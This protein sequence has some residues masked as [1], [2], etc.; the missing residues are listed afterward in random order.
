MLHAE[1]PA[2]DPMDGLESQRHRAVWVSDDAASLVFDP[3]HGTC[4]RITLDERSRV[5]V[6]RSPPGGS[7]A[8]RSRG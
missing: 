4:I 2:F 3:N 5:E 7:P 1:A 8:T 6:S